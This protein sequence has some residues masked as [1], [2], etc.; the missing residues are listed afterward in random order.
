M[1]TTA[2]A[3]HHMPH[4]NEDV[5]ELCTCGAAFFDGFNLQYV[6]RAHLEAHGIDV[7]TAP[8][9]DAPAEAL[10]ATE[11]GT[12]P[13]AEERL[14]VI[15]D[16]IAAHVDTAHAGIDTDPE[17]CVECDRLYSLRADAHE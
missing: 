11:Y 13:L 4:A 9:A 6:K 15:D 7:D 3:A 16:A 1:N 14:A 10:E 2:T 17:D 12:A 5:A 8:V